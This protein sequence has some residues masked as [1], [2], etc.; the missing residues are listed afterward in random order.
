MPQQKICKK[1]TV[2]T[3]FPD[4]YCKHCS[5]DGKVFQQ[6]GAKEDHKVPASIAT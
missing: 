4:D 2:S 1:G 5:L 3:G 6:S